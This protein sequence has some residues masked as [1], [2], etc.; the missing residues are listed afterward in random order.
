MIKRI[1]VA[2]SRDFNDYA[3]AKVYID[4][5]IQRIKKNTL[6][7]MSG[8]CRGADS[9]GERYA[10]ENGYGIEYYK[11][12]WKKYGKAAGPIRNREMAEKCDYVICFWNG[13]S[14]GTWSM[15]AEAKKRGKEVR[16]KYI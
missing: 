16:I 3:V 13:K 11:P 8:G 10:L 2:G 6:I 1:V 5:C 15:I 14:K 12:S 4:Y 9:L 7:F